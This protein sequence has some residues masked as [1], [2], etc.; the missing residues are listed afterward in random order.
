M[1]THSII[2]PLPEPE[3]LRRIVHQ[4]LAGGDAVLALDGGSHALLDEAAAELAGSRCRVLRVSAQAAGGLSLSGV[5]AQITGRLDL[6]G[7]DDGVLERGFQALTVLDAEC[8]RIVLMVGDAEA[9]QRTALRYL[10]FT[11]R[12]APA[13]RLV[14]AGEQGPPE[15]LE[16]DEMAFLRTRLAASPMI[17]VASLPVAVL[18]V[19][20]LPAAAVAAAT[21]A[22]QPVP[23]PPFKPQLV[24]SGPVPA[25][26]VLPG[27]APA[28]A[29]PPAALEA[30]PL[31]PFP[32]TVQAAPLRLRPPA[33]L[34]SASTARRRSRT[35]WIG[36]GMAAS[37][38]AGV[39]IGRQDWPAGPAAPPQ[40]AAAQ[41]L[42]AVQAAPAATAL[43]RPGLP[44]R[45]ATPS[46]PAGQSRVAAP[47]TVPAPPA[48]LAPPAMPAPPALPTPPYTPPSGYAAYPP[49]AED[50]PKAPAT[51]LP[52][53]PADAG[54]A[55]AAQADAP[56][57]RP[58]PAT[59][60]RPAETRLR[61]LPVP[62]QATPPTRSARRWTEAPDARAPDTRPIE[63][64]ERA[65]AGRREA[66]RASPSYAPPS[67][68]PPS[69][70][71]PE[72]Q[73]PSSAAPWART[74]DERSI[75][76]TY[77]TDQNGVRSFRSTQ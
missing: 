26:P 47:A 61:E 51:R 69:A 4:V 71:E 14:L 23:L 56:P 44:P 13:L 20:T 21:Q 38:A 15:V 42:A 45:A 72:W 41:P 65:V 17:R 28:D 40:P 3:A 29:R 57:P 74:G 43:Q 53:A 48:T 37:V 19:A 11:C 9:L 27:Q 63:L 1:D 7:H 59:L 60:A 24:P 10:Q 31:L 34:S 50:P 62:S 2:M 46:Q 66:F 35:A 36:L 22:A 73:S 16:E 25:G 77:T 5:M 75:V 55:A 64:R 18:P 39:L 70:A 68:A 30:T 54:Q 52:A 8:D 33:S 76:G 67:Y 6:D 49:A 58:L 12:A 32:G